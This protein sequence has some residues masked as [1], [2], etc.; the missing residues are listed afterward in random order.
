MV[1]RSFQVKMKYRGEEWTRTIHGKSKLGVRIGFGKRKLKG[2]E[3]VSIKERRKPTRRMPV[4][5]NF[6]PFR[7]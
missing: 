2:A 7:L 4:E 1:Q 6:K 3:I 5:F